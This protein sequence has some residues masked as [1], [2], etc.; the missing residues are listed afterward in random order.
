MIASNSQWG[1]LFVYVSTSPAHISPFSNNTLM[2]FEKPPK[3]VL[4]PY[5]VSQ[6]LE[7][8]VQV[9]VKSSQVCAS[10]WPW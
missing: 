9:L 3:L 5:V 7:V 1:C 4:S 2:F 8:L 6:E 10:S